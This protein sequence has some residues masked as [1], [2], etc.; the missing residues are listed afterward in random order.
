[1]VVV[2]PL[3][4]YTKSM[5]LLEAMNALTLHSISSINPKQ[6]SLCLQMPKYTMLRELK[7]CGAIAIPQGSYNG[8]HT[9]T[10]DLYQVVPPPE[11]NGYTH[12]KLNLVHQP[13]VRVTVTVYAKI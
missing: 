6:G 2:R 5:Y 3:W 4:T 8:D 7:L 1:M 12:I 9:S 13:Q 10:K 11:S